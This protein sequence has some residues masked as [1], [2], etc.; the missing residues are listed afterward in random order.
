LCETWYANGQLASSEFFREGKPDGEWREYYE[1]GTLKSQKMYRDYLKEG[2][3]KEYFENG[4]LQSFRIYV[5]DKVEGLVITHYSNGNVR[6][7]GV[8][9][10]D[11]FVGTFTTYYESGALNS[12]L[13]YS[14]EGSYS[15]KE[16]YEHGVPMRKGQFKNHQHTGT[17]YYYAED[18]RLREKKKFR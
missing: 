10:H 7:Q 3:W 5:N 14:N 6:Y 1:D 15:I 16:Y 11:H 18:G 2:E 4:Q 13:I 8:A 17:W 12:E 9:E